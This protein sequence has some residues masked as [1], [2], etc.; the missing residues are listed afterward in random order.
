M[1]GSL[2][3]I[4]AFG[5]TFGDVPGNTWYSEGVSYCSGKGLITG[6][7]DGTFRPKNP[8]TR[9]ELAA[10]CCAGLNLSQSASNRFK[11]VKSDAWYAPYVLKCV[12]AGVITGYS[13]DSFGP[14][15]KVT[16]EQ[17][18]VIAAKV[19]GLAKSGGNTSFADNSRISSWAM[20]SVKAMTASGLAA[21]RENNRFCPKDN[22]TRAEVA[23]VINSAHKKG[24]KA[25]A[26]SNSNA[27]YGIKSDGK[28]CYGRMSSGNNAQ[29]TH[30]FTFTAQKSLVHGIKLT[31]MDN[32]TN[33]VDLNIYDSKGAR[34]E[35]GKLGTYSNVTYESHAFPCKAGETYTIEIRGYKDNY[36]EFLYY[37]S[38]DPRSMKMGYEYYGTFSF[39]GQVETLTFVAP[40]NKRYG[41]HVDVDAADGSRQWVNLKCFDSKGKMIFGE[42]LNHATASTQFADDRLKAGETYTI[43][44]EYGPLTGEGKYNVYV[45]EL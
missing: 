4:T 40:E 6:Y 9:A 15:D 21:G 28:T 10:I 20:S 13:A 23:V 12:Q 36:Y 19:Y 3:S 17:A 11:D 31:R 37:V 2:L 43:T 26:N 35:Y 34:I 27:V 22:V 18:A 44:L 24:Y 32:W 1:I 8:I 33:Y 42:S 25:S 41:I 7:K 29:N 39:C 16:R 45:T 14:N 5:A 38:N 30:R